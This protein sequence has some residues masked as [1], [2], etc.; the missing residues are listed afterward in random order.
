MAKK[1]VAILF[2]GRSVE[3]E[4][5]IDSALSIYNSLDKTKYDVTLVGIDHSG[6]WLLP[7]QAK[8]LA[9][10]D[11]PNK[12]K[13]DQEKKELTL[14][15]S[16]T[17][18]TLV[19]H[20]TEENYKFD[21]VLPIVH[22]T[23]GEDGTLQGFLELANVPYVGAGVLGSAVC[24]D[25]ELSRILITKAGVPCVPFIAL[26]SH[27]FETS[28]LE[29]AKKRFGFPMFVKA[30][31]LGSSV[32]VF[33]VND[34]KEAIEKIQEAF[35]YDSKILIEKGIVGRELECSVLGNEKPEASL[36]GEIIPQADFYDYEAKYVHQ[37]GALL[38]APAENLPEEISDKIRAYAVKAFKA[39][40]CSGMARIDFFLEKKTGD[41][42]LNEINTLPGFT[43]IS[44]Y[45]KLWEVSGLPYT[46]LLDKLID[47]AIE[48]HKKRS[49]LKTTYQPK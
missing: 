45:P 34:E 42:Y 13:L 48:R 23:Y 44:M 46:K 33:K 40:E 11:T 31:N 5:S 38:K 28:I 6:R 24:M 30:A 35:K 26:K 32:G 4:V 22:G 25:K 16:A 39:A 41:I 20:S 49:G 18:K 29:E 2:G 9:Q 37:E 12:I 17:E 10:K 3:H 21:V 19:L 36:L 15:P 47:L 1:R 14:L 43:S 27:E 7:D 8:L